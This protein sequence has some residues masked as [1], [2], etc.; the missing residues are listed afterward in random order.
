[1]QDIGIFYGSL[2]GNTEAAAKQIQQELGVD[3]TKI[4]DVASAKAS[5]VEQFCNLIFASS[6]MG[7]GDLQDDFEDFMSELKSANLKG[8]KVAIF[9]YGDQAI[10]AD[11]FVDAIG[12]I[13]ETL[14][15]KGCVIT[16]S[17]ACDGYEYDESRA[18]VDGQFVGL[19]LDEEN[20][21][22]LTDERIRSWVKQLKH[23]FK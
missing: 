1:M 23:E 13:Y 2:T 19:P 17:V 21:S 4:Y 20:Q 11:S 10:Y 16:G 5:D 9:G 3:I 6:T 22:D 15:N 8:K 18:E 12:E 14:Q 7:I